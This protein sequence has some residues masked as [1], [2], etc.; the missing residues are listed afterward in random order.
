M[1]EEDKAVVDVERSDA[2]GVPLPREGVAE[3]LGVLVAVER[4][5]VETVGWGLELASTEIMALTLGAE[6]AVGGP[7]VREGGREGVRVYPEAV[8]V[9][10]GSAV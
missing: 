3:L 10:V 8:N 1:G 6:E 4:R 5:M 7:G 9:G 2:V